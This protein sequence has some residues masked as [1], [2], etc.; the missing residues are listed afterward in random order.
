MCSLPVCGGRRV[1]GHNKSPKLREKRTH[2][3]HRH[4]PVREELRIW[5]GITVIVHSG[6]RT[7]TGQHSGVLQ[8]DKNWNINDVLLSIVHR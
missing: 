5:S 6:L 8:Q 7:K 1:C 2:H 3:V 4:T